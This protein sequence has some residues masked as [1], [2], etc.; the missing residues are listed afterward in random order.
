MQGGVRSDI[1]VPKRK[2]KTR[3]LPDW[4]D[5]SEDPYADS[6]HPWSPSPLEEE[7]EEEEEEADSDAIN[8]LSDSV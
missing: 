6:S 2:P 7:E 4:N 5:L 1:I 8:V 3:R